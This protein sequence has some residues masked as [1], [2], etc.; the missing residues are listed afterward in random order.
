MA[1]PQSGSLRRAP[2]SR[3]YIGDAFRTWQRY[4][5]ARQQNLIAPVR[6]RLGAFFRRVIPM[7]AILR[8]R[9]VFPDLQPLRTVSRP[10]GGPAPPFFKTA[11]QRSYPPLRRPADQTERYLR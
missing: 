2:F 4:F 10:A 5:Q 3:Q 6:W 8:A 1:L 9:R 7:E 11:R